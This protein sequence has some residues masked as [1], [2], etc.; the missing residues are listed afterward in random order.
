MHKIKPGLLTAGTDKNN[1]KGIIERFVTN[2]HAF[3]FM[4]TF[5]GTSAY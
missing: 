5:K 1:F 4:S 3:S 2:D